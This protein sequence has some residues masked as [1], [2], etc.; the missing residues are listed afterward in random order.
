MPEASVN[1]SYKKDI[2]KINEDYKKKS[3]A[4]EESEIQLELDKLANSRVKLVTV[5]REAR[6][7]DAVEIDF[8]V[9]LNGVPIEN[10]SN[11]KHPL[12]I[13]KGVFIPG[14]EEQ[15]LG[16][17]ENEE[18]EFN[19]KFPESYHQ[20][21]LAGK[22]ALFKVKM[23]IVQERQLPE[24]NDAFAATLG[25]FENLAGLKK[26]I[27]EGLEHEQK[28]KLEERRRNEYLEKILDKT[29]IEL[30]DILIFDE[31]RKMFQELEYQIVNMGM[32][33]DEYLKKIN[34]DRQ[35]LEKDW[36]PQAVKRVKSSLAIRHIAKVEE[37]KVPQEKIEAEMNKTMA[38]Y[39]S[40]KS[41]EKNID[42]ERLYNYTK[43]MLENEE[44][45][46]RLANI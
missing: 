1:D 10:G 29:E 17:K 11:K 30:P 23:N 40:I 7:N 13:G 34:K 20:K 46:L 41:A 33:L 5:R 44:V 42:L 39:K 37:I 18:K 32:Q 4:V 22:A 15:L 3:V 36:T 19:L 28:H 31:L 25:K 14:F 12:I 45:F 6:N 24:I 27:Q 2:K 43:N 21:N 16:M 35:S 26:S 38:Y 9:S 8:S